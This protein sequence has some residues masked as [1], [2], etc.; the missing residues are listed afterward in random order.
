MPLSWA[1]AIRDKISGRK[2]KVQILNGID[3][4][5]DG[6]S[7]PTPFQIVLTR[8]VVVLRC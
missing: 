8:S 6:E 2:R 4:V 3:G 1:G 7:I 5:L